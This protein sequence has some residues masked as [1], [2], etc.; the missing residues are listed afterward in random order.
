[1]KRKFPFNTRLVKRSAYWLPIFLVLGVPAVGV[2][3]KVVSDLAYSHKLINVTGKVVDKAGNPI[4]GAT[5]FIKGSKTSAG[6]DQNGVFRMNLP[7]GNEVLVV[8]F[9]GYK[10]QEIAVDGRVNLSITL[11]SSAD[12]LDEVVVVGYG[13]QKK[14]HLTG[15][16]ETISGEEL[17][18]LPVTN[19]GAALAGRVLGLNVS[20]GVR[21]PGGPA[22]LQL[23]NP[24]SVSKDG[25]TNQPLYV[26]DGI[27]Q[28][29]SQG[30]PDNSLFN[31]LSPAE[32]ESLSFLKDGSAAVYGA[33]GANGVVLVTTRRG[34]SGK[35]MI[36][37][38]GNYGFMDAAYRTEMMSAYDYAN[39][40]NIMNGPNGA[41]RSAEDPNF[42]FSP[43]EV[44]HFRTRSFDWLEPAW[45]T[46]HNTSHA[47]NISGGSDRATY[48]SNVSY[49]NQGGNLGSLDYDRWNF[50]AGSSL[51][52]AE[53]LKL[54]LQLSGNAEQQVKTFNKLGG[55]NDDNDYRNLITMPQYIP[56]YVDGYPV[57][58][59]G[60]GGYHYYEIL[61][62][63]NLSDGRRRK[64]SVNVTAEYKLPFLKELTARLSYGSNFDNGRTGRIGTHYMLYQFNRAG[65]NQHIYDEG[66]TVGNATRINNDNR[67]S[68]I[69]QS[70]QNNQINFSLNYGRSFGK[71]NVSGLFLVERSESESYQENLLRD[72]PL[73]DTNGQFNSAFGT[74]DGSTTRYEAGTLSYVGR[75][76]WSYGNKYMA[77]FLF[78]SDASTR[79]APENY[80]GQFYTLSGGWVISEENFFKSSFVDLL[81]IRYSFGILGKDDTRAWQWRQRYTYQNG[82]GAVFG[83]DNPASMGMKM[84]VS[85]NRN[86]RWS[87]DYKNNL[88]IDAT[89]LKSRLST[90]VELFYNRGRNMLMER[91][92][93]VPITVGGSIASENFGEIDMFGTEF[94]VGWRDKIG[95]DFNYGGSFRFTWYDNKVLVGNFSP[96]DLMY[97]WN[98]KPDRSSD[99]GVWGFDHLGMFRSQQD[100]DAYVNTYNITSLFGLPVDQ[101]RPGMLYYRDVRGPLQDD[102]TFADPDGIVDENDRVQISRRQAAPYFI[103]ST[104]NASYKGISFEMVIDGSFGGHREMEG[105]MRQAIPGNISSSVANKPTI[106]NDI[107]D[108]ELNPGGKLPNPHWLTEMNNNSDV[109]INSQFWKVN[110]LMLR[111]RNF[112]V[113]YTLPQA[114]MKPYG[115]DN[116]RL[117]FTALNPFYIYNPYSYRDPEIEFDA[118]PVLRSFSLGL[119]VRF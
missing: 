79:F 85:P 47:L 66:A 58:P 40:I 14:I 26:I 5:V 3:S 48:F 34:K 61:R 38:N 114:I 73:S 23:R 113:G 27:I 17:E 51:N 35:P 53:G 56:M 105:L 75:A 10:S 28:V 8:S 96:Q 111:V 57:R 32:I 106:W 31:T 81:K 109:N 97:P 88:G 54:D 64:L 77:E 4:A 22:T 33:R 119:N 112:N 82:K 45:K 76:N 74:I 92:A 59:P 98:P 30:A 107:Y 94:Q 6:T 95:S 115:V 62:L 24:M 29:T 46:A 43:D 60:G 104:L 84:E 52:V 49:V 80:W 7:T 18:D 41:N 15:A 90:T 103:G 70:G 100:I 21:R 78:R 12:N 63:N 116:V 65:A 16:V 42:F 102:G 87:D 91:T 55:E 19:V 110:S 99:I 1:M 72:D 117:Y 20:G 36:S 69:N 9:V 86:A 50:R 44:E 11:E 13:Q 71:H 101:L 25:G 2:A 37:Y 68:I 83:G 108:P 67:L 89:F 39:Y 93:T 118:Y